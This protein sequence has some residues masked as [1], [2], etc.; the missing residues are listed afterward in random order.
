MINLNGQQKGFISYCLKQNQNGEVFYRGFKIADVSTSPITLFRKERETSNSEREL[1][2]MIEL[3]GNLPVQFVLA[4]NP[5]R[6][7]ISEPTHKKIE[8]ICRGRIDKIR[9]PVSKYNSIK[10]KYGSI[11][12]AIESL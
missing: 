5:I 10:E 11:K 3:I 9:L 7:K 8:I 6:K 12:L 1:D 4:K 2:S